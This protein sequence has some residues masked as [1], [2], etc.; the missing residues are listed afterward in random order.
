MQGLK[1]GA[2][3]F[4]A[5]N[6][7]YVRRMFNAFVGGGCFKSCQKSKVTCGSVSLNLSSFCNVAGGPCSNRNNSRSRSPALSIPPTGLSTVRSNRLVFYICPRQ[8][9]FRCEPGLN[10]Q[11]PPELQGPCEG[12][13]SRVWGLGFGVWGSRL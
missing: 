11:N 9:R 5:R 13:G 4:E 1:S 12:L 8:G 6:S 2:S 7:R 3:G 10:Y